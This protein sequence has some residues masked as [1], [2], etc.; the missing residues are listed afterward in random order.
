[1]LNVPVSGSIQSELFTQ[2]AMVSQ[3]GADVALYKFYGARCGQVTSGEYYASGVKPIAGFAEGTCAAQ[4]YTVP[5]GVSGV[6]K[7]ELFTKAAMV[8]QAA[9]YV[10]HHQFVGAVCDQVTSDGTHAASSTV[11]ARN[12]AEGSCAAQ[13]YSVPAGDQTLNVPVIGSIKVE[14]FTKAAMVSQAEADVVLYK[15][16]GAKCGQAT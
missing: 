3:V 7:I 2:A 15:I 16:T 5:A 13:G 10:A 12:L 1:M 14:F 4:G 8:S 11:L 6:T 9:A